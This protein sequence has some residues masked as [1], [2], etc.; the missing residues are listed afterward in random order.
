MSQ[1]TN[2]RSSFL[3]TIDVMVERTYRIPREPRIQDFSDNSYSQRSEAQHDQRK[4][5]FVHYRS[6]NLSPLAS[7]RSVFPYY[8]SVLF[9]FL[10][11]VAFLLYPLSIVVLFFVYMHRSAVSDSSSVPS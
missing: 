3:D 10:S 9:W 7:A 6:S 1:R 8:L 11:V 4:S 5:E 2:V